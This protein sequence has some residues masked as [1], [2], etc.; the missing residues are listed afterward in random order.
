MANKSPVA[1]LNG[2]QFFTSE[3][4][5][6]ALPVILVPTLFIWG[7]VTIEGYA[8]KSSLI[9][10]LVLSAFLGLAALGQT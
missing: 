2:R 5:S 4:V 8:S 9:S 7:M 3:N 10:I 1:L 6:R